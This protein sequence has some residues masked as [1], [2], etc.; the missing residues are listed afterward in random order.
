MEDVYHLMVSLLHEVYGY[1]PRDDL[2]F[3][4]IVRVLVFKVIQVF[5][6][7]RGCLLEHVAAVWVILLE[8]L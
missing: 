7:E 1:S 6:E 3:T 2:L 8:L 4:E 5:S